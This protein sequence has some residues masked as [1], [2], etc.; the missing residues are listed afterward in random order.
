MDENEHEK[1]LANRRSEL[2]Q[3]LKVFGLRFIQ[4][5]DKDRKQ[6]MLSFIDN[7]G[8]TKLHGLEDVLHIKLEKILIEH[9]RDV[10][11]QSALEGMNL[12]SQN[13]KLQ[14]KKLKKKQ[15]KL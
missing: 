12:S 15:K 10:Y 5:L 2:Q 1:S 4:M 8:M 14:R 3:A 6:D 9:L 11:K 13:K 7:L